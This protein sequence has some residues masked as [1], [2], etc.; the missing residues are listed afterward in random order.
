MK[1]EQS[2][3]LTLLLSV[4][5]SCTGHNPVRIDSFN[6]IKDSSAVTLIGKEI[7]AIYSHGGPLAQLAEVQFTI[8][9]TTGK[10]IP[11][12]I[13]QISHIQGS[14]DT[15]GTV[16]VRTHKKLTITKTVLSNAGT[17]ADPKAFMLKPHHTSQINIMYEPIRVEVSHLDNY[18]AIR[19]EVLAEGEMLIADSKLNVER[20][21]DLE[22]Q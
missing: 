11:I 15:S 2:I 3:L 5:L 8:E 14:R 1:V 7:H 21:D 17:N 22:K 12:A 16:I 10:E 6:T 13:V 20:E 18:Q 9:N 19:L 4:L